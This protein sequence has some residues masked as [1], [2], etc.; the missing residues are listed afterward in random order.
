MESIAA[1]SARR[2]GPAPAARST[3]SDVRRVLVV[4]G[5]LLV[6]AFLGFVLWR[7][8]TTVFY[9]VMGWFAALAME[10]AVSR[11]SRRMP[12]P[13]AT[14]LVMVAVLLAFLGFLWAFGSLL[15]DQ[16]TALVE[17][18]PD[19][20]TDVLAWVNRVTGS[21]FTLDRLLDTAGLSG[22]D[23]TAYAQDVAL[24][25]LG[26]LAAVLSAAFGLFV[27]AF[28]VFYISAGMPALRTWLARRMPPRVQVPFLTAWELARV[29]VG[30]YIAARV[31]LASINVVA[32][33]IVFALLGLPYWLPLALWTGIVAQF[34][35][36]VGTYISIAL[37]ALVGFTSG[38]PLLGVWVLA[39]GIAY[40]QVENLTFEPR[41]SARAV[42]VHPAVSFASALLGAQ[43]FGLPGALVG[44][45]VAAT[46]M[47]M[48]E[49]Y[50]RRYELTAATEQQVARLVETGPPNA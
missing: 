15:V 46:I 18:A 17:A 40:Q 22:G 29:K 11:L 35:P 5:V 27:I 31:V 4:V 38:E 2:T 28:F 16:L 39:W 30:G 49:I 13:A 48:L 7:G 32:S 42:D 19:I 3:R 36:N 44:V 14:G 50:Q 34:I 8:G 47:A 37:P 20:A 41:I 9:V 23:L 24:G 26:V 21:D 10:P 33:G 45:P 12:R 1:E 25:V 6:V 43:L